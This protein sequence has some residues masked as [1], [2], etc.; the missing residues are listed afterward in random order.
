MAKKPFSILA[1]TSGMLGAAMLVAS[2][3][4]NVGPPADATT[5]AQL[6]PFNGQNFDLILWGA[7]LQA[8]G[9]VFIVLFAF[10]IVSV[11]GGMTRVAG[12]MTFF[13]AGILM[14]VSLVEIVFYMSALNND[15]GTMPVISYELIHAVQH[16]YFIIAAPALF[17]PLG[18]VILGAEILPRVLGSVAVV[19]GIAFALA[20]VVTLHNLIVPVVVQASASIQVVWWL[21]AA[22][23]LVVRA[24][25]SSGTVVVKE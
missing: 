8:V 3:S 16:L 7:W 2:F 18:I 12:W 22:I 10:A 6:I 5:S 17:I 13:G 24:G 23:T 19:L 1:A 9:P 4:M 11:A 20:G 15:P 25:K 21:A 14:T